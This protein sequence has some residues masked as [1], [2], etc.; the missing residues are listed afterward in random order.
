MW[1]MKTEEAIAFLA[2]GT[3]TG[4]LATASLAAVPHVAPVWFVVD[5]DELVFMTG[6]NTVKG[7]NL[8]ENPQASLTAD[9]EEFPYSFVAVRGPVTVDEH[10]ADLLAWSIRIAERYVPEDRV[11]SF[12]ER[13]AVE[14]ELLC[15]LRMLKVTGALDLAL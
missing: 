7:R 11:Q 1:T 2:E 12:G 13:N 4:K 5:G 14:G 9:I 6:S 10:A 8:R 15:R 3:R